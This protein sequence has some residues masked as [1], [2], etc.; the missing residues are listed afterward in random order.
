[1]TLSPTRE[2]V[3]TVAGLHLTHRGKVRDSY[4]LPRNRRL[5]VA[6]DAISIFDF[7]L[8]A[9]VPHKGAILNAISHFWFS[10][11]E[12][13]RFR[14]HM[15]AAGS[16]IDDCL[17]ESLRNNKHLQSHAMV[18]TNLQ[19]I[20][21]EFIVRY[22][23]TGS[24]LKEY[25]RSGRVHGK[26]LPSGL[27]DGDSLPTPLF[28]PTTKA[29]EGHDEPVSEE[30]VRQEHYDAVLLALLSCEAIANAARLYG[31][32][33]ADTKVEIGYDFCGVVRIGD[34]VG[35]PDSSR[36]WDLNAWERSRAEKTRRAPP[37]LDKQPVRAWGIK[38][39]IDKLDPQNPEHVRRVHD[40][41]VPHELIESTA[42]TYREIFQRLTGET[43][44]TYQRQRLGIARR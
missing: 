30:R 8:S 18:V 40:M 26:K 32:V 41:E 3:P 25:L 44:E 4:E 2:A 9:D 12:R 31:I 11:L 43:L 10:F 35:T 23:L 29:D 22:C 19:M 27:Q 33:V 5:V 7:T 34:E 39:G 16:G 24:A 21:F 42:A 38:M 6:T 15:L 20:S 17:P 1:M 14:T 36:F 13:S 37:A 28:T